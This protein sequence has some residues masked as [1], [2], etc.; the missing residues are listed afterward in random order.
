MKKKNERN[1]RK[2]EARKELKPEVQDGVKLTDEQLDQVSGGAGP[3]FE[4]G[5]DRE[6]SVAILNGGRL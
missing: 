2:E 3:D 6:I 5:L 4:H 1:A